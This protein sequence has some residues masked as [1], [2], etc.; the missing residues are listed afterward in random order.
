[1]LVVLVA[2]LPVLIV[3]FAVLMGGESLARATA[4]AV[5]ARVLFWVAMG[6][7]MLLVV[8]VVLLVG[9]LGINAVAQREPPEETE[10]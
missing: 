1:M 5:S 8:D 4:D 9:A 6:A 3:A 7:L 2:A 10:S